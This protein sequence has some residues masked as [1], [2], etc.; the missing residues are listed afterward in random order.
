[1]TNNRYQNYMRNDGE[2]TYALS[3]IFDR[4]IAR[5]LKDET[6]YALSDE[7]ED[8]LM[9]LHIGRDIL[10]RSCGIVDT[11]NVFPPVHFRDVLGHIAE[12]EI[13]T[14]V[15]RLYISLFIS[16]L[17][18][19]IHDFEKQCQEDED[20]YSIPAYCIPNDFNAHLQAT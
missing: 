1:M 5:I 16:K 17:D 13:T 15:E 10:L 12:A 19:L 14:Q 18:G 6:A 3:R 4:Y 9:H 11:F 8:L 2:E 7:Q 20:H